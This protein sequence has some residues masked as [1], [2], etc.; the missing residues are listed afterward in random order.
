MVDEKD[1]PE[2]EEEEGQIDGSILSCH[3]AA[4]AGAGAGA[5]WQL[6]EVR[7]SDSEAG[8]PAL[9][10]PRNYRACCSGGCLSSRTAISLS[11]GPGFTT[12]GD[13]RR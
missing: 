5:H 4:D 2:V 12:A 7:A 11:R 9:A 1:E 8:P 13:R 3:T 10:E 6:E